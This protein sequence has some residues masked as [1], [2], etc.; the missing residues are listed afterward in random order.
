MCCV[1][2]GYGRLQRGNGNRRSVS[3]AYGD[4]EIGV[5]PLAERKEDVRFGAGTGN[6]DDQTSKARV[7]DH[8]ND[9]HFRGLRAAHPESAPNGIVAR[10][11]AAG[12]AL[13]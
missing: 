3:R 12:A 8:A 5:G 9:L 11:D 7:G 6:V 13:T 10:P 2:G 4:F 1:D